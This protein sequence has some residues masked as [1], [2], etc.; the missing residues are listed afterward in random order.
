MKFPCTI[1]HLAD[2]RC[3]ARH[4]APALGTVE[5][6]AGSRDE[7]LARLRS[8]LRY[9]VEWCPCSGVTDDYVEVE[10]RE[11]TVAPARSKHQP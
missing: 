11:E 7:A 10:V 1:E 2:G 5:V 8:E 6:T 9:R 3:R 4:T